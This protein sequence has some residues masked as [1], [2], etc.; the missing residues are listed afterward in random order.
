MKRYTLEQREEQIKEH[1]GHTQLVHDS[2]KRIS[3]DEDNSEYRRDFA[4]SAM[5]ILQGVLEDIDYIFGKEESE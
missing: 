5:L 4:R 1:R 3:E 2:F